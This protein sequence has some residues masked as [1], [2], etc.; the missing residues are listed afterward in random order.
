M[1]ERVFFKEII[2]IIRKN[3]SPLAMKE[4][5][6]QYH[7]NDIALSLPELNEKER[8][9]LYS[10]LDNETLSSVIEYSDENRNKYLEE[11]SVRR[12][13]KILEKIETDYAS[14]YLSS[15]PHGE[16]VMITEFLDEN[17]KV[18][19][20]L[21][22]S[23][24]DDEIGSVMSTNYIHL[25]YKMSI[26]EAMRSLQEQAEE[27]DNIQ[28]L[29]VTKEIDTYYGA[30]DLKDLIRAREGDTLSSIITT[31]FPYVYGEDLIEEELNKLKEYKEDSIPVLSKNGK[32]LGAITS[33]TIVRLIGESG[34]EDFAKFAQLG[35]SEDVKERVRDGIKKRLPWLLLLLL[36][37]TLVSSLIGLYEEVISGL[38]ILMAFQSLVLDMSGNSGTQSLSVTIRILNSEKLTKK[39]NL[40]LIGKEAKTGLLNGVLLALLAFIVE[41]FYIYFIKK[42]GIYISLSV[43]LVIALSLLVSMTLSSFFGSLIPILL[44]KIHI[45]PAVAS[46]PLITTLND[47]L[48]A[49]TYYSLALLILIKILHFS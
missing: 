36:L 8:E 11:I 40:K 4:K 44:K 12:R 20:K 7:E 19:L 28:T 6:M 10:L 29:Y 41:T 3:I 16:R 26:K 13:I 21:L 45:D 9:L 38:V 47:A 49:V 35:G 32:L 31:S 14:S 48:G 23:F 30:I 27:N 42:N 33:Q 24:S 5:L 39:E 46:G 1:E 37:S 25:D 43:S 22:S 17:S 18:E 2:S 15:I 34:E